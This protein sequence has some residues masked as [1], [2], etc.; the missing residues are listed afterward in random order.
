MVTIN[1]KEIQEDFIRRYGGSAE[2]LKTFGVCSDLTIL[3]NGFSLSTEKYYSLPISIRTYITLRI[4]DDDNFYLR[5]SYDDTEYVSSKKKLLSYKENV[6]EG[7]IFKIIAHAGKK[8]PGA[9]ILFNYDVTSKAFMNP[10]SCV[11]CACG[12]LSGTK[13]PGCHEFK[14]ITDAKKQ[15]GNIPCLLYGRKNHLTASEE[16]YEYVPFNLSGK[17]IILAS[18]SLKKEDID[19]NLLQHLENT[20]NSKNNSN[21][22]EKY[23]DNE[24]QRIGQIS[25]VLMKDKGNIIKVSDKLKK[26]S[27]EYCSILKKNS[28]ALKQMLKVAKETNFC[29]TVLV[30]PKYNAIAAIVEEKNVDAFIDAFSKS[31]E[32]VFS[33]QIKYYIT[34]TENSGTEIINKN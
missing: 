20:S 16:P 26:S 19:K 29:D 12:L 25:G 31:G 15:T 24:I 22:Y 13:I 4:T 2:N 17:K 34:E 1:I 21:V 30:A 10:L 11:Y 5:H 6:L 27:Y 3:G 32:K 8:I 7:K 28:M 23:I 18:A 9:Q 33:S 14:I